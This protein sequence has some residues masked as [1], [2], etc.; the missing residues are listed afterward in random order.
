MYATDLAFASDEF[1]RLIE[2]QGLTGSWM[3]EFSTQ[4]QAWSPGFYRLL[5]L[6]PGAVRPNYGL[7]YSL[8]HPEDRAGLAEPVEVPRGAMP[9]ESVVRVIRPDGTLRTLSTRSEVIVAA[10]G[11]PAA[12]SGIVLDVTEVDGLVRARQADQRRRSALYLQT[13]TLLVPVTLDLRFDFPPEFSMITGQPLEELNAAPYSV[14]VPEERDRFYQKILEHL[15]N[16]QIFQQTPRVRYVGGDCGQRRVLSV[17]VRDH[18]GAIVEW[19]GLI[20][21]MGAPSPVA[22]GAIRAG[23]EQAV[24]GHH[25][26][27]ARALLDWSMSV[28]AEASGLSLSTVR[29]LEEGAVPHADRSRHKAVAALRRAGIRF[30]VLDDGNLAV[31]RI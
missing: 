24:Q 20:Y 8:V 16:G 15:D 23:L 13:G 10:D 28:L 25:L 14:I 5:G 27:A 3:W 4:V 26:R 1:L 7:F 2:S 12:A 19:S 31:T 11:R 18:R 30:I 6:K 22:M 17:P 29:R 9:P 21:P